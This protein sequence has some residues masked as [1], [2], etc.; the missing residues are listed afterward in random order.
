MLHSRGFLPRPAVPFPSAVDQVRP[1][2]PKEGERDTLVAYEI[3]LMLDA[4]VAEARQTEIVTRVRDLVEKGGG[5][6]L[7]HVPWGKRRLAYEIAHKDEGIYHLLTFDAPADTVEEIGRI[8]RIDDDVMRH[9]AV[10]RIEGSSTAAPPVIAPE[11]PAAPADEDEPRTPRSAVEAPA[12]ADVEAEAAPEADSEP[13][14][15]APAAVEEPA[16][17]A[18]AEAEAESVQAAE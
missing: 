11:R 17:E 4:D 15:E 14:A 7:G 10:R 1:T 6:W 13:A 12:P 3:L 9:M 16:A 8:L 18:P 5:S 2:R